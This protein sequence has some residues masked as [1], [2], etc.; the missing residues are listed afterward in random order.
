M[1]RAS[2]LF[3][4]V[5][6][7]AAGCSLIVDPRAHHEYD[8]RDAGGRDAGMQGGEDAGVDAGLAVPE[9]PVLRFPWNG[10]MTGSVHTG[11]LPP[12]RNALRPR[13]V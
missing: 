8:L 6:L 4:C 10:Y 1:R 3:P 13:F 12:E 11:A 9:P 7:L 2:L 5:A